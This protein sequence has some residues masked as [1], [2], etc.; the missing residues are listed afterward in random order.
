MRYRDPVIT[1]LTNQALYHTGHL[2]DEMFSYPQLFGVHG[3]VA[4]D[5]VKVQSPMIKSELALDL[6]YMNESLHWASEALSVFGETPYNLMQMARIYIIKREYKTAALFLKRLSEALPYHRWALKMLAELNTPQLLDQ[7]SRIRS[8]RANF[9]DEDFIVEGA[10]PRRDFEKLISQNPANRMAYEYLLAYDLL[11]KNIPG[12]VE[13]IVHA[14]RYYKNLM[15]VHD[16]EALLI[17]VYILKGKDLDLSGFQIRKSTIDLFKQLNE[18][19]E[20]AHG[21]LK[22]AQPAIY[23]H[24]KNTYW[25]YYL[26][27]KS[28]YEE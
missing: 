12:F 18:I 16:E 1:I 26:Y 14:S 13:N 15:P 24:L 20:K 11:E 9:F 23:R 28:G 27:E 7:E 2:G 3:L 4:L 6:G 8:I 25:Y 19:L 21:D 22:T 17:Y 10:N 5:Q